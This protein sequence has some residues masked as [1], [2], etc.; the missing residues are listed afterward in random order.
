MIEIGTGAEPPATTKPG[1]RG[2]CSSTRRPI[3][4]AAALAPCMRDIPSW[5]RALQTTERMSLPLKTARRSPDG[6]VCRRTRTIP[7]SATSARSANAQNAQVAAPT[8]IAVLRGQ[9]KGTTRPAAGRSGHRAR[10]SEWASLPQ[11]APA[12]AGP[13]QAAGR[14]WS[15]HPRNA[16]SPPLSCSWGCSCSGR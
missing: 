15:P 12:K 1:D 16:D 10:C 4:A 6:A 13:A 7:G 8:A 2:V 5:R 14:A 11:A 9:A 3:T